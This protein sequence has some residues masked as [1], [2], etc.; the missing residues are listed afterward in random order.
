MIIFISFINTFPEAAVRRCSTKQVLLKISQY[1]EK[2]SVLESPFNLPCNFIKKRPQQRCFSANIAKYLRAAFIVEHHWWLRLNIIRAN[3][4]TSYLTT[5]YNTHLVFV[6]LLIQ[7]FP[8]N[9]YVRFQ[10]TFFIYYRLQS[11][12]T[13]VFQQLFESPYKNIRMHFG[14]MGLL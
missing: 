14:S 9:Q 12:S 7:P 10:S 4:N 1:R 3:I 11:L 13:V 2:K 6:K 8:L 5:H